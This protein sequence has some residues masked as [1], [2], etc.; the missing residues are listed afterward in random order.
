MTANRLL[1]SSEPDFP[2]CLCMLDEIESGKR[3]GSRGDLLDGK[4][5]QGEG[6]ESVIINLLPH[7]RDRRYIRVDNRPLLLVAQANLTSAPI[8]DAWR[9]VC[10]SRGVEPPFIVVAA[11]SLD[12][13][14]RAGDVGADAL[15]ELPPGVAEGNEVLSIGLRRRSPT[16]DIRATCTS[17]PALSPNRNSTLRSPLVSF[18]RGTTPP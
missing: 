5:D 7:F 16:G 9:T 4:Y 6:E 18:R 12:T 3:A 15:V 17:Q 14:R 2:Y 1:E 11:S 10:R 13:G 8:F